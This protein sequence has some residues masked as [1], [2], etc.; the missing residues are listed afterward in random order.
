MD[1]ARES[2]IQNPGTALTTR[3]VERTALLTPSLPEE[4]NNEL[5]RMRRD[6]FGIDVQCIKAALDINHGNY[7][8]TLR[9]TGVPR[10]TLMGW[11]KER[12]ARRLASDD[13]S[14]IWA[15]LNYTRER[16]GDI[17]AKLE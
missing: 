9:Q 3:K 4:L 1:V 5:R 8:R 15:G 10:S 16:R 14:S 13:P 17:A 2:V 7:L 12:E 11:A 6:D